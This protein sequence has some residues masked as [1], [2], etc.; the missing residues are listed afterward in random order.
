MSETAVGRRSNSEKISRRDFRR[1]YT[2]V[3]LFVL[4]VLFYYFGELIDFLGW[5][6]LRWDFFYSVHDIQRLL[7]LA[8]IV[9]AGYFFGVKAAVIMAIIAV[10]TFLPRAL[11]VSPFPD[12]L[13]RTLL[14]IVVAG[15]IGYLTGRESERRRRLEAIIRDGR[16][17]TLEILERMGERVFIVGPEYRIRFVNQNMVR[18][19]GEGVGRHCYE[20]LYQLDKP[21]HQIC[22]LPDVIGGKVEKWEYNLP[23]GKTYEVVVSPY[24]DSDGAVCQLTILRNIT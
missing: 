13:L 24:V 3:L 23:D 7:F 18:D 10:G 8:P 14:F 9:Y 5:E 16:A 2:M 19:R 6:V 15:T 1:F 12:P 11:F 21:C 17:Q 4:C 20:Y 22:R